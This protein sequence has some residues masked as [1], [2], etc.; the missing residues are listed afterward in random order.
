MCIDCDHCKRDSLY[1][2]DKVYYAFCPIIE[3]NGIYL[4]AFEPRDCSRFRKWVKKMPKPED[5]WSQY[6]KKEK[7]KSRRW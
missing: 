7:K 1:M 5:V 3:E 2:S 4:L 6:K